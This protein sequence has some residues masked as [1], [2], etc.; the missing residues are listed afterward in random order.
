MHLGVQL[1]A[2]A[3]IVPDNPFMRYQAQRTAKKYYCLI[4]P[5]LL[6]ISGLL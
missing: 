5:V 4:F 2:G 3:C 6:S 1:T